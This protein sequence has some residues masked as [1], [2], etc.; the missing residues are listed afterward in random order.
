MVTAAFESSA[1][2]APNFQM[3]S[4]SYEVDDICTASHLQDQS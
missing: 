1:P 4:D 3:E 2:L